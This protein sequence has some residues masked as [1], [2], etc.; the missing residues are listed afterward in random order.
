MNREIIGSGPL[1]TIVTLEQR[2]DEL[3]DLGSDSSGGVASAAPSRIGRVT[4][5]DSSMDDCNNYR[6]PQGGHFARSDSSMDDCN[7]SPRLN[8]F[9]RFFVQIPLWTIVTQSQRIQII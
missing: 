8:Y 1:W 9:Q 7:K 6:I 3:I 4:G 2:A 5:S